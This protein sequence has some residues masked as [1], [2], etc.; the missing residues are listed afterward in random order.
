MLYIDAVCKGIDIMPDARSGNPKN[1]KMQLK[2][3]GI[4][5][6]RHA[7]KKTGS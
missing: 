7:T 2:E 4:E 3:E 6:L 5:S 1:L